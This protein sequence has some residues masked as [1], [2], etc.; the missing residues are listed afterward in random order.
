MPSGLRSVLQANERSSVYICIFKGG[1]V[2]TGIGRQRLVQA[3]DTQVSV[4]QG[5]SCVAKLLLSSVTVQS[6]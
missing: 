3:R 6:V 4:G 5:S 1:A 2:Q